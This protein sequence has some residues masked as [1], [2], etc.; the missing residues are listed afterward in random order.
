MFVW[1][2]I[3]ECSCRN[4]TERS[5]LLLLLVLASILRL[6]ETA[7]IPIMF[8]FL[9][10]H[11]FRHGNIFTSYMVI[12]SPSFSSNDSTFNG[13][14]VVISSGKFTS[15]MDHR[16]TFPNATSV[17]SRTDVHEASEFSMPHTKSGSQS[18]SQSQ[19]HFP[20]SQSESQSQSHSQLESQSQRESQPESQIECQSHSEAQLQPNFQSHPHSRSQSSTH[21]HEEMRDQSGP[22]SATEWI[23]WSI[24]NF[25]KSPPT[26][27]PL[28]NS[29]WPF[30]VIWKNLKVLLLDWSLESSVWNS[31]DSS[32]LAGAIIFGLMD[33]LAFRNWDSSL[34][35]LVQGQG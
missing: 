22:S 28:L 2:I 32:I 20:H 17:Q 26:V 34:I 1:L 29:N 4:Q 5:L 19:F 30:E 15:T 7:F 24:V 18:Y 8:I 23:P 27:S 31:G 6:F 21:S 16:A 11:A 13:E 14:L 35:S 10:S 12:L 9:E 33:R 25:P 3:P